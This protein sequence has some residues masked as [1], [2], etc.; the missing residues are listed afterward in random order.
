MKNKKYTITNKIR[1]LRIMVLIGCMTW[2]CF[3]ATAQ[4]TL[5]TTEVYTG[6][7]DVTA[8]QWVKL[9]PGFRAVN[10][11]SVHVFI[12]AEAASYTPIANNPATGGTITAGSPGSSYNYIRSQTMR[13]PVQGDGSNVAS[14][15]RVEA[16]AY[17]DGLGRPVQTVTV[18]GSPAKADMIEGIEYDAFGRDFCHYLPFAK[19]GNNGAYMADAQTA[20]QSYYSTTTPTTG[21]EPTASPWNKTLYEASPLNRVTGTSGPGVWETKPTSVSYQTNTAAIAHWDAAKNAISFAANSLYMTETTDEDGNKTREYKDKLGQ[22]VRKESQDGTQIMRTA[23]VYDDFGQLV[24]VVP[25][26]AA[27]ASDAELCYY[28]A[29]DQRHRMTMKDLPGAEPVYMVYDNRDR[30]ALSQDG[31]QRS[32]DKWSFTKYDQ[33]NRPVLTGEMVIAGTTSKTIADSFANFTGTLYETTG[34]TLYGYTSQSFPAAYNSSI[35]TDNV[36]TATYYD[37][38]DFLSGTDY[39]YQSNLAGEPAS[40]SVKT[41]G[42]VTGSFVKVLPTT[43]TM[44]KPMA[45]TVNYYDDYGRLVQTVADNHFEDTSKEVTHT[46]CNFAGQ[47][48]K[49]VTEHRKGNASYQQT[50]VTSLA[51]DHQGRLLTTKMKINS[52]N[53]FTLASLKY[54]ELGEVIARYLHGDASGN[55]FNQ[56]VDYTYNP[57]GWLRTLNTPANLGNDLMALDLR[58]NSPQT[59]TSLGGAALFNGNISQ[60]MWASTGSAPAQAGYGFTYDG[61]NR[62]R[63][64]AYAEGTS[65]TSGAGKFSTTYSYDD[66]GNMSTLTRN[67]DG[68]QVDNLGYTYYSGGNRL[69]A[70]ADNVTSATYKALGYKA[71][72]G[73]YEYDNNGNMTKDISKGFIITYNS[74]NLPQLV[75]SSVTD[76][77]RYTYDAAG[78]K[79][80]KTVTNGT[81]STVRTDYSGPF[82]Y[83]NSVLKCIFTPEGRIVPQN[84]GTAMSYSYEYNLKDHLGNTRVTFTGHANGRPEV[85][86]L[87]SYD[88]YGLVTSQTSFY[89]TGASKNKLLYN[90]KEIQ[91]DVLAGTKIDWFDYGK[92]F[93]DP[94]IG[95]WHTMDP[96]AESYSSLSPYH[97]SGNNPI[98]FIDLN[99]MNYGDYY[100]KEGQWLGSDGKTDDLMYS[101]EKVTKDENGLVTSAENSQKMNIK[102]SE[103]RKQAAAIYGESSIGYGITSKEEMYA[104]GSTHQKN[105]IAYGV[106]NSNAKAFLDTKLEDQNEGMRFANSAIINVLT[107]GFD[108]SN[109]ADQWDGAE[110]AMIPEA[111][112]DLSSNGT[113]MY[114]MNV[115]GW[116]ITDDHYKSWKTA[117][118]NKFGSGKFTVP[119]TKAALHDYGGMKNTGLIRLTSTAQYGL[120]IFW[121]TK[122]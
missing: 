11:S 15:A 76:Y 106:N 43:E 62:L 91:D 21:H 80:A 69:Q 100:N 78:T 1:I 97:F 24:I 31:V 96:L 33:F 112:M 29:Y 7:A 23:Y 35:T 71:A 64:A 39:A 98:R 41:K 3:S 13:D 58:Y 10:G 36:L 27:S 17:F 40:R 14:Y 118:D 107:K 56:Q 94:E 68:N 66:N 9:S 120:T 93:Y 2:A 90:G 86:Q 50:L 114:K 6:K 55:N 85:N 92:R 59:G 108:Y 37:N 32:T 99:G 102:H 53:E 75:S 52:D 83:E 87:T 101:A 26:K 82:M 89:P 49:T 109:G 63:S 16:I 73:N 38:Y 105:K 95:R 5:T 84:N 46:A 34:T 67:L 8:S 77:A 19:A 18:Q 28:Y 12:S 70:V 4:T 74:L 45:L 103:F 117:I 81:A 47:P 65:Y 61:L 57:K 20:V 88:P 22:V 25:P 104:I 48:V 51:Y 115:M 119:Q 122:P 79:L 116:S 113:Y 72:S 60:M 111:N 42:L 30:L 44:A 110:Q 54:N 121:K